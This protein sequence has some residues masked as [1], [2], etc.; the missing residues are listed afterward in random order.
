MLSFK[1]L[2]NK[3]LKQLL[4]EASDVKA[5][6]DLIQS[7]LNNPTV[8]AR[9]LEYM[10]QAIERPKVEDGVKKL[11]DA[12]GLSAFYD[13]EPGQ[14]L[15][16]EIMKANGSVP[17][18]VD[19]LE[20][21]LEGKLFNDRAYLAAAKRGT[22]IAKHVNRDPIL[23]QLLSWLVAWTPQIDPNAT[24]AVGPTEAFLILMSSTGKKGGDIGA[25]D[26]GMLGKL[27]EVKVNGGSMGKAGP[28]KYGIASNWFAEFMKK[29]VPLLRNKGNNEIL[30]SYGIGSSAGGYKDNSIVINNTSL[31][32]RAAGLKD[33][34]I[35]N[36]WSELF[37]Q[38]TGVKRKF[39]GI[40]KNGVTD[41][42]M[43]TRNAIAVAFT[44]YKEEEGFDGVLLV[45]KRNFDS[46][47]FESGDDYVKGNN[48]KYSYDPSLS[49]HGAGQASGSLSPR[50]SL[51]RNNPSTVIDE[52]EFKIAAN[53]IDVLKKIYAIIKK[54][55]VSDRMK[56]K[57][58]QMAGKINW[59]VDPVKALSKQLGV[60]T[61]RFIYTTRNA[62]DLK[63][64]IG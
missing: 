59:S 43:F 23:S 47:W 5:L 34:E 9:T 61:R 18:K 40:V 45:D 33:N 48:S 64:K 49:W 30:K 63:K 54:P 3:P 8:D 46:L 25:G 13:R 22:N 17:E 35:E 10:V 28:K 15:I 31:A 62:N 20:K 6:K 12:R 27:I 24:V 29:N 52:K 1:E 41:Y 26:V 53:N 56:D 19:F 38:A 16:S 60:D 57:A 37:K 4:I 51:E 50:I 36:M 39:S 11:F 2:N 14:R 21:M 58:K 42:D 7:E 55:K 32:L 44:A